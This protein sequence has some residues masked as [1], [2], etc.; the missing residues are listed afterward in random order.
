M[1][2]QDIIMNKQRNKIIIM[3]HGPTHNYVLNEKKN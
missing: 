2:Q 3:R 1:I